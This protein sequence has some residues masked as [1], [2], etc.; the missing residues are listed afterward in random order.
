M[1][2]TCWPP[3][4]GPHMVTRGATSFPGYAS[5]WRNP[6]AMTLIPIFS[7]SFLLLL[8]LLPWPPLPDSRTARAGSISVPGLRARHLP[9]AA[10]GAVSSADHLRAQRGQHVHRQRGTCF[11]IITHNFS[12]SFFFFFSLLF[13][14]SSSPC[15]VWRLV[16]FLA[17]DV[18]HTKSYCSTTAT[19]PWISSTPGP[20]SFI[21][22]SRR[23]A[24]SSWKAAAVRF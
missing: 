21:A 13:F 16:H 9:G 2:Q 14:F 1:T 15:F 17:P 23:T 22:A 6:C 7:F 20:P 10:P 19:R 4:S 11:V 18:R 12:F 8:L 3:F 5:F 24:T